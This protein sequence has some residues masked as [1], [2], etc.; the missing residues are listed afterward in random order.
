MKINEVIKSMRSLVGSTCIGTV[1]QQGV[2][3]PVIFQKNM[4]MD[5]AAQCVA[6][7]MIGQENYKPA[8]IYFEYV[9][10][11][12]PGDMPSPPAFVKS[13]GIE[14]FTGLQYSSDTDFMRVPVVAPADVTVNGLGNYVAT[15]YAVTPGD[16]IGFWGKPFTAAANSAVYGGA[17]VA[18]PIWTSQ[19]ND[20]VIARNYPVGA[21]V[22]KPT[23]EQICIVWSIEVVLP[24]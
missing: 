8:A 6:K 16:V 7:M 13:D 4:I 12:D 20:I 10:L 17:L 11:A 19:P 18:S 2:F 9:N 15:F 1:N 14:Y 22:L 24:E 23:G 5:G 3:T 21:K